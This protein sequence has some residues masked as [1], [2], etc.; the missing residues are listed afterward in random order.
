ME[1]EM[2][3]S[4]RAKLDKIDAEIA[5]M[6][7]EYELGGCSKGNGNVGLTSSW[8][9]SSLNPFGVSTVSAEVVENEKN[10]F[11][12]MVLT[13]AVQELGNGGITTG[14]AD[15]SEL[16]AT[17]SLPSSDQPQAV[18]SLQ[19]PGKERKIYVL[20]YVNSSGVSYSVA[21]PVAVSGKTRLRLARSV[22]YRLAGSAKG[23]KTEFPFQISHLA[24]AIKV[25]I[26]K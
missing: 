6:E 21:K 25:A 4:R 7:V 8:F 15:S 18:Y 3:L 12:Q 20:L 17:F 13:S 2:Q 26:N 24:T 9:P 22:P 5:R 1:G 23:A 14:V 16:N 11:S 10:T 19:I